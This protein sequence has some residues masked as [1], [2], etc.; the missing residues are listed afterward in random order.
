MVSNLVDENSS[1]ETK[2]ADLIRK[3]VMHAYYSYAIN[4]F[5]KRLLFLFQRELESKVPVLEIEVNDFN[6]KVV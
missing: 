6:E 4:D 5:L 2:N 3:V 1:L